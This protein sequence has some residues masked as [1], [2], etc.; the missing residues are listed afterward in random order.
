M[1]TYRKMCVYKNRYKYMYIYLNI[2]IYIS[3]YIYIYLHIHSSLYLYIFRYLNIDSLPSI[4]ICIKIFLKPS[5]AETTVY[6]GEEKYYYNNV[7]N[8]Q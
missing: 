5:I 4:H 3:I 2:Y 7:E 8:Q 6:R 1:Y